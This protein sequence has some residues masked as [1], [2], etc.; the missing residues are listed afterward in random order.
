MRR[1][2]VALCLLA[3]GGIQEALLSD[4]YCAGGPDK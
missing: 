1:P 3:L 4:S 2:A